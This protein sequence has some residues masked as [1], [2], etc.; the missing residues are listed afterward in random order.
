MTMETKLN[1]KRSKRSITG[2]E[3][4]EI[5]GEEVEVADAIEPEAAANA[6]VVAE[7]TPPVKKARGRGKKPQ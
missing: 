4:N 6:A 3:R 1:K 5:T 2:E 7:N